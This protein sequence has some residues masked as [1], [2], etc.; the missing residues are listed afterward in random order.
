MIMPEARS[1][2]APGHVSH[3]GE[4]TE[5]AGATTGAARL[6]RNELASVLPDA[7]LLQLDVLRGLALF[8][9]LLVNLG[10]FSG[11]FWAQEAKLPYPMG[12]GGSALD[13][14][15]RTVLESKAVSLLGMLYGVGLAIQIESAGR[16]GLAYT[17]FALRRAGALALFGI[18]HS[19]LLWN[20]D[21]LLDYAVMS[22]LVLPFLVLPFLRRRP[23]RILWAIP[24]L[25]VASLVI[26]TPFLPSLEQF[27]NHPERFYYMGLEH[28][29]TGSWLDAL[30]FRAWELLNVIGPMR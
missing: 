10:V 30:K 1:L 22:L 28:Y 21:I 8:G 4:A 11:S 7:R 19:L 24:L 12:W 17:P 14:A 15:V 2:D 3:P 29:G 25:V 9:V 23:A 27:E 6:T 16:K 18:A 13:F 20:M 26:S 5:P